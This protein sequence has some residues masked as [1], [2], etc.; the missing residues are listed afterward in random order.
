MSPFVIDAFEFSRLKEQREGERA[1]AEFGRLTEEIADTSGTMQWSLQGGTHAT[2]VPL[3]QLTVRGTVQLMCQRC[4]T[5][6]AFH[7]DTESVLALAKSEEA[8]DELESILDDEEIDVIVGSKSLNIIDLVEDDALLAI[9][10][11]P[12]HDVCPDQV[13]QGSEAPVEV[14]K[15]SPFEVLKN[16]Q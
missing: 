16:K 5:P 12:K 10:L 3:L 14:K 11:S 13:G 8:A 15:T 1:V 9:P 6:Y 7:V 4:L 2:G